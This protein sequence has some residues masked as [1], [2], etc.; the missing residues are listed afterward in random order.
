MVA[1]LDRAR[2][3]W[4][5]PWRIERVLAQSSEKRIV[6]SG[7]YR[8]KQIAPAGHSKPHAADDRA[9]RF[10]K[11]QPTPKSAFSRAAGRKLADIDRLLVEAEF[12]VL[13]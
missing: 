9:T 10:T 4:N 11:H 2:P 13:F 8:N 5:R 1:T 12:A 7:I 3:L 6:V